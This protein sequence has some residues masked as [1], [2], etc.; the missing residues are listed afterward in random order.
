[1]KIGANFT[2]T[3]KQ[4]TKT[5]AQVNS[6]KMHVDITNCNLKNLLSNYIFRKR[7]KSKVNDEY[8]QVLDILVHTRLPL[9]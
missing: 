9:M 5:F 7:K 3:V 4:L 8:P 6:R 1:M 2:G